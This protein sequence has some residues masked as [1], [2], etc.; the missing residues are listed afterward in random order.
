MR[1][2]RGG[3]GLTDGVLSDGFFQGGVLSLIGMVHPL[4]GKETVLKPLS[5]TILILSE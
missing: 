3:G 4:L 5:V 2:C 1:F